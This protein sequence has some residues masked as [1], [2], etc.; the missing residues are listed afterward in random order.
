MTCQVAIDRNLGIPVEAFENY[1]PG[2]VEIMVDAILVGLSREVGGEFA[3]AIRLCVS[4]SQGG[5]CG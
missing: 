1:V 3:E 2:H 4:K 5:S